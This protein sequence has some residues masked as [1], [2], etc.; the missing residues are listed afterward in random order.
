VN[1][2]VLDASA[3]TAASSLA[4]AVALAR[5]LRVGVFCAARGEPAAAAASLQAID[6][7][8]RD[9]LASRCVLLD[10]A[11]LSRLPP[12]HGVDVL[13]LAGRPG[14][15]GLQKAAFAHALR[16]GLEVVVVLP[17]GAPHA[18]AALPALLAP[19]H[20]DGVAAVFGSRFT[21]TRGAGGRMPAL[22]RL[23]NR[24]VSS[25]QAG[26]LRSTL[27]DF[28]S[29]YRVYRA[30]ALARLPFRH[31]GDGL[32]FD[33]ELAIQLLWKGDRIVE[34]PVPSH[35][36]GKLH[37]LAAVRYGVQAIATVL[38]AKA[39]QVYLV[40]HPKF[41]VDERTDYLFKQAPTSV[42][43]AVLRHPFRPATSVLELGAGH[44]RVARALHARGLAVVAVDHHK[45]DE[46]FPF[47]YLE[48]DLD[49]P[50]S[51]P[52]QAALGHQVDCVVALDVIE[53]LKQPEAGLQQVRDVLVPGGRLLASTGNIAFWPLRLMLLFGQFNYGKKGILDRTHTRLFSVRS[54]C[55]TIEGEGFRV[56]SVRG[57]GPPIEDMVGRSWPLRLLDRVANWLARVWPGMFAYQFLVEADVGPRL[58]VQPITTAKQR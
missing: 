44:G 9:A 16:T 22:R 46:A 54:F 45:P 43:Q 35:A 41:D 14:Y 1:G 53:H 27:T 7:D 42:H 23:G 3:G 15:G 24:L 19:L 10:A 32:Q 13:A 5:R 8:L 21:P 48:H 11:G 28:H 12:D 6:P 57:F 18:A 58:V 34:V 38:R 29:G 25:V 49:L 40:Y 36:G 30:S 17:T 50:F 4:S 39:N 2:P 20:E 37:G 55:R 33:S 47:P 52:V 56:R 31:N 51:S 26:L